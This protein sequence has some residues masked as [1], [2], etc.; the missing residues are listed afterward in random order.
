MNEQDFFPDPDQLACECQGSLPHLVEEGLRL[1]N[2]GRFFEAH[3]VLETAWRAERRPVRELYRGIL[4]VGVGFYHITRGNF[5][6]AHKLF[7]RAF[8]WLQPFPDLCQGIHLAPFRLKILEIDSCLQ[9][10]MPAPSIERLQRLFFRIDYESSQ[11][12][13]QD[14]PSTTL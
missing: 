14:A 4:Q 9:Q 10:E 11:P 7:Q 1:F 13:E 8:R 12:G 3:E 6:G 5:S 2:A